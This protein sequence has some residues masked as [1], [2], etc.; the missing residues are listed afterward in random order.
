MEGGASLARM[1]I[2]KTTSTNQRDSERLVNS[3]DND[4][5]VMH[6]VG[7]RGGYTLKIF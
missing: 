4:R 5:R 3:H 7:G 6:V 1:P 2:P